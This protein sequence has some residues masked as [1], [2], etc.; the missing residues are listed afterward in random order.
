MSSMEDIE[1]SNDQIDYIKWLEDSIDNNYLDYYKYSEFKNI[2]KIGN[3]AFGSIYSANWKNTDTILVLKSFDNNNQRTAIKG[4]VNELILHRKAHFHENILKFYGVT[5]E[6][7]C[8]ANNYALVLEYAD[9]GTLNAYLDKHFNELTWG[10]KICLALQL[11]S[12]VYCLHENDII[13]R[14]LHANNIL[15]H[16][17]N[18][19][20]ADFGLS[21]KIVEASN[22]ASK[23]V[24]VMAYIDPK[25]LNNKDYKLDKKSDVY[26]VGVIMWQ[27]SSGYRPFFSKD[28]F[29]CDDVSF[30][31]SVISG[32]RG[33]II[34]GTPIEYSNLYTRCWKY[35]PNE[36][37]HMEELVSTLK[38]LKNN[39]FNERKEDN[40][41]IKNNYN[42][43]VLSKRT[44]DLNYSSQYKSG[45]NM[46]IFNWHQ[47]EAGD[48]NK[49]SQYKMGVCYEIG[50]GVKKD[51]VKAF[52]WY[53]K[54]AEQGYS[55]AQNDLGCCYEDSIGTKKNLVKAVYWYQKAA[56]NGNEV[57]QHNLGRCYKYGIGV[58]KDE[59]KALEWYNKSAKQ[60][61]SNAQNDLGFYYESIEKDLEK[62]FYWYQKAA[63]NGNKSAQYNLGRWYKCGIGVNKDKIK[64]FEW[65]KKSAE[66]GYGDAQNDLGFCYESGIGVEKDL[67]KA[68]YWYQL[69]VEI[70]NK[71]AQYNLSRLYKHG[72]GV[73]KDEVKAF[74]LYE[75]SAEQ[76]Y[77]D[78]QSS[79]GSC[80]EDGIGTEINLVNAVYW[81][82][83]AAE[84]G[85]KFALYKL[86]KCYKYGKGIE[87]NEVKAFELYKKSA[88]QGHN[89]AQNE[90]GFCYKNGIGTKIDLEKAIYW[91]QKA[92]ENVNR[93]A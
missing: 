27:I 17:K 21:R 47:I 53:K 30:L 37:P 85:N 65:Y 87:K 77:T 24:G 11:A 16:Q 13:H 12:A 70:G 40:S 75:K 49:T 60:D 33:E 56:E 32:R 31:L 43:E 68:I 23:I 71:F 28:D 35:E 3:G 48:G 20:V 89:G 38:S 91:Y 66:Q 10:D 1:Y 84:K 44:T 90:L 57:A 54:S 22:N 73:S 59:T 86:G 88:E 64:A 80:Y 29:T 82:N 46:H 79:L 52:E 58:E 45:S 7:T 50:D 62:A 55:D 69:A 19:K 78:A 8:E 41:S 39:Y 4:V 34:N 26:S 61:H 9:S 2:K 74:E 51:E 83:K 15:I 36:R 25:K 18:I 63:E 14:D 76:G 81:Y 93:I 67:G 6:A 72:D 92:A 5:K 42:L